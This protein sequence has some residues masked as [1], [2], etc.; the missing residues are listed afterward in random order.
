MELHRANGIEPVHYLLR[1]EKDRTESL[2]EATVSHLNSPSCTQPYVNCKHSRLCLPSTYGSSFTRMQPARLP[3]SPRAQAAHLH[4]HGS[5]SHTIRLSQCCCPAP[6][7]KTLLTD[8]EP[9]PPP[10]YLQQPTHATL[11]PT[12]L[13]YPCFKL[14][15]TS[16]SQTTSIAL[17]C[18]MLK[19][20]T[21]PLSW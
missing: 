19:Q 4:S 8:T 15:N 13:P 21:F 12:A 11:L 7:S 6:C 10:C 18:L 1:T 9:E 2:A 5:S 14:F 16:S 3:H 17:Q 20:D